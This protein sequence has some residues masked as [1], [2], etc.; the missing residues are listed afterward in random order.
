MTGAD[1]FQWAGETALAVSILIALVMLVRKPIANIF[2]AR[3][4]YLL[5]LAP[6]IRI[7]L[8]DF[9]IL[10]APE[11]VFEYPSSQIID[12]ASVT[13]SPVTVST[14]DAAAFATNAALLVWIL[15]AI[16]WFLWK[17]E[18]QSRY[19]RALMASSIPADEFLD[20]QARAVAKSLGVKQ[21]LRI[22]VCDTSFGPTVISFIK[23]TIFLPAN[24]T[25]AYST[26]E[27]RL[28]LTHEIAHVARGDLAV[29]L[30]ALL[31]QAIQ[32]PNPLVHYAM[33]AFKTDQEA[34]CDAYVLARTEEGVDEYASAILK[35][36]QMTNAPLFGLSM[37]H[38]VKERL[39]LIK[40]K[41]PS[42]VRLAAGT[43]SAIALISV[44]LAATAQY[45]Y[46]AETKAMV[47]KG[48]EEKTVIKKKK[49]VQAFSK[50]GGDVK[51]E[52]IIIGDED[53]EDMVWVT[54][55]NNFDMEFFTKAGEGNNMVVIK[56]EPVD[57]E[58][59]FVSSCASDDDSKEP[60]KLEWKDETSDGDKKMV[61]QT[62]ICLDGEEATDPK[63]RAAALNKAIDEME[64]RAKRDQERS[65]KMIA[66]LRKQ[67]R[68]LEKKN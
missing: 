15:V 42:L 26:K 65:K 9:A 44:G 8:P 63:A 68:D 64:A 4:A 28:A 52:H 29:S 5:W 38:P 32:W 43:V 18:T 54:E 6:T 59:V 46:A 40:N 20:G 48:D 30:A 34:A 12:F 1:I 33:R 10:P 57:G 55:D 50:D 67:V 7:F 39:M 16:A 36:S 13:I 2:G 45:S 53:G 22:R 41:K 24:F 51:V 62:F 31:L 3:I 17:L 14:F 35:S 61:S 23:P 56:S 47:K 37:G 27:Q 49:R 60:V 11:H 19:L 21:Q 58:T 25:S 66:A